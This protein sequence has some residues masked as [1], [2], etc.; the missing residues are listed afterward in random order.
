M[1][2]DS[3]ILIYATKPEHAELR[4]WLI[5]EPAKSIYHQQTGDSRLPQA[6]TRRRPYRRNLS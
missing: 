1:L 4:I 3:N 5:E 6:H 2:A